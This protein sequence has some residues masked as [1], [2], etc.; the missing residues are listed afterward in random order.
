[1][2]GLGR[3]DGAGKGWRKVTHC[4][5]VGCALR[6]LSISAGLYIHRY[7]GVGVTYIHAYIYVY[8]S[9]SGNNG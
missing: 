4:N 6:N 8:L 9:S 2:G 3:R 7:S 5:C 1:M